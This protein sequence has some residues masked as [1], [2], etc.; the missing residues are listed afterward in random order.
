MLRICRFYHTVPKDDEKCAS[1]HYLCATLD[2]QV[3]NCKYTTRPLSMSD[4]KPA[5]E[6]MKLHM[7]GA[8]PELKEKSNDKETEE[9]PVEQAS[10]EPKKQEIDTNKKETCPKCAKIFFS[11]KNVMR[12]Y[13]TQHLNLDRFKCTDCSRTFASKNAVNYHTKKCHAINSSY[14]CDTCA[15]NFFSYNDFKQHSQGHKKSS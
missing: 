5:I 1:G 9:N 6:M 11:N 8:H 2:C 12:H 14:K 10:S 7:N 15:K 4:I 3:R 13:K